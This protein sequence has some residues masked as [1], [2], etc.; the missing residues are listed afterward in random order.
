MTVH[1]CPAEACC[2]RAAWFKVRITGKASDLLDADV[3]DD[4]EEDVRSAD[5]DDVEDVRR[6]MAQLVVAW[7]CAARRGVGWR[8]V[9]RSHSGCC[10]RSTVGVTA[11][12]C[13][14]LTEGLTLLLRLCLR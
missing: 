11:G 4:V 8:G 9:R 1:K 12:R 6:C 13:V 7:R 2:V 14:H 5:S 3:E 10:R